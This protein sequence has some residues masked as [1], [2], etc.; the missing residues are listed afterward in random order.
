LG[1]HIF[2]ADAKFD[3]PLQAENRNVFVELGVV[4]VVKSNNAAADVDEVAERLRRWTANP[5]G[6]ARVGSNPIFVDSF[7]AL[8]STHLMK[9]FAGCPLQNV[10]PAVAGRHRAV[11]ELGTRR[12]VGGQGLFHPCGPLTSVALVDEMGAFEQKRGSGDQRG[13]RLTKKWNVDLN[14][15]ED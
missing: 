10:N 15:V 6:S 14:S 2:K 13:S 9:H 1:Q 5:M 7:F 11:V 3:A 8:F 4:N 12:P